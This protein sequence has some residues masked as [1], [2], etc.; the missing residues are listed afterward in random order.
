MLDIRYNLSD[1]PSWL[2]PKILKIISGL[3]AVFALVTGLLGLFFSWYAENFNSRQEE[4]SQGHDNV[5]LDISEF[6]Y[7]IAGVSV[8][9]LFSAVFV[10]LMALAV[11]KIDQL[12]WLNST[13]EDRKVILAK[14]KKKNAKN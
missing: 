3:L 14:R 12:V 11:D 1:R 7:E 5:R 13:D 2:L 6:F 9:F 8:D 4:A 10:W